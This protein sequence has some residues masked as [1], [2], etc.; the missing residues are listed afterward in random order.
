MSLPTS[1]P[2]HAQTWNVIHFMCVITHNTVTRKRSPVDYFSHGG[3]TRILFWIQ[4]HVFTNLFLLSSGSTLRRLLLWFKRL[5]EKAEIFFSL[6]I[7]QEFIHLRCGG[8]SFLQSYSRPV[9]D[10]S[11]HCGKAFRHK[12]TWSQPGKVNK[13]IRRKKGKT[14]FPES[15]ASKTGFGPALTCEQSDDVCLVCICGCVC[16]FLCLHVWM[17]LQGNWW[18]QRGS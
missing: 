15:F 3:T 18:S 2:T 1:L 17:S 4:I 8:Q 14:E 12:N 13:A 9:Q 5:Y 7:S 10:I 16:L 6:R 11:H